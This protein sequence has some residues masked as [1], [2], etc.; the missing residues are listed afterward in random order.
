MIKNGD[1]AGTG[2]Q[3]P[4]TLGYESMMAAFDVLE[5]KSIEPEIV[6][7]TFLITADNVDEFGTDGW[8]YDL[9]T[10]RSPD[11]RIKFDKKCGSSRSG[12]SYLKVEVERCR[13][14]W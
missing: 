1:M 3:S 13:K 5:G 2:S 8:Q 9:P 11:N 4:E 6:V 10:G 14:H 7:D 12:C